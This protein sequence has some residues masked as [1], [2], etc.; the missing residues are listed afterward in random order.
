MFKFFK[1]PV[2]NSIK[3][4]HN[5]TQLSNQLLNKLN[6]YN[7]N[8]SK[9]QET[10]LIQDFNYCLNNVVDVHPDN[11]DILLSL[12]GKK[13]YDNLEIQDFKQVSHPLI[14]D[15]K[16]NLIAAD[17][18]SFNRLMSNYNECGIQDFRNDVKK[19]SK[20]QEDY[21]RLSLVSPG[22][23]EYADLFWTA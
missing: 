17:E 2:V 16:H 9:S 5:N 4:Y 11:K 13:R 21:R 23:Q 7:M 14:I 10:I 18:K 8:F 1:K 22:V 15:Y 20:W 3:V 19:K 6:N 12:F